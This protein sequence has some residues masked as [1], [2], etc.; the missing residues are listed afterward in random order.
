MSYTHF[1]VCKPKKC[2]LHN[3]QK[4]HPD[5]E[6]LICYYEDLK[7][8]VLQK[9]PHYEGNDLKLNEAINRLHTGKRL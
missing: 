9:Y 4:Y 2:K 1:T 5:D 6:C 8:Q 7:V 3:W